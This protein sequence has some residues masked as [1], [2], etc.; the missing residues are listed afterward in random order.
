[1]VLERRRLLELSKIWKR[2][3][4]GRDVPQHTKDEID[5]VVGQT[6]L[7]TSNKFKQ[8]AELIEMAVRR[9]QS[10]KLSDLDGFWEMMYI[11]VI[12]FILTI[13][14]ECQHLAFRLIIYLFFI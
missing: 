2:E 5:R 10:I 7:L 8:F 13:N 11:Q 3:K 14:T 9:P 12:F 1:L 4:E 6:V